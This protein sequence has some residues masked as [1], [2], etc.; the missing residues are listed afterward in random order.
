MYVED[1]SRRIIHPILWR[2]YKKY[3]IENFQVSIIE[4]LDG[5]TYFEILKRE[6]Y[7]IQNLNPE[8]NICKFPTAGGKPNLGRKL[9]NKWK[10]HI[11]EKSN[12]YKHNT[13]SLK[14]VIKNNKNNAVKLKFIKESE[15]M[16]LIHGLK[17][18]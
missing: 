6:E 3:G 5:K 14:L 10:K 4:I 9:S 1:S 16:N 17:L 8:Y 2:A 18:L 7:Y 11:K 12:N 13:E 15:N